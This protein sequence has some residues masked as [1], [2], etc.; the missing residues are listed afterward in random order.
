MFSATYGFNGAIIIS[1]AILL[2]F[3]VGGAL[4][5]DPNDKLDIDHNSEQTCLITENTK[6]QHDLLHVQKSE[7]K[8]NGQAF[9]DETLTYTYRIKRQLRKCYSATLEICSVQFVLYEI[10]M[11]FA[12]I[13]I[14][15]NFLFID[16]LGMY[17][18]ILCICHSMT[19]N[20]DAYIL[21]IDI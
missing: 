10:T 20:I 8:R 15:A 2:N 11:F 3:C 4:L 6:S 21:Y 12:L 5:S 13:I 7:S 18:S 14:F 16:K 19:N 1:G 17:I 9:T